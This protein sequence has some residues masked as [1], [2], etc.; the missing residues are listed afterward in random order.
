[1]MRVGEEGDAVPKRRVLGH[2][3]ATRPRCR[4]EKGVRTLLPERPEG[5]FAQKGPDPFFAHDA[6][7]GTLVVSIISATKGCKVRQEFSRFFARG[8]KKSRALRAGCARN[9]TPQRWPQ[10]GARGA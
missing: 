8:R 10:R 4:G 7:L 3:V 2:R 5:C 1:M 6:G 9:P